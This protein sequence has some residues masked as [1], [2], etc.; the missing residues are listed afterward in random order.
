[1]QNQ[2]VLK[3]LNKTDFKELIEEY[4]NQVLNT[5]LSFLHH[6]EDAEDT[7]QEVF[8]EVYQSLHRFKGQ[9][10]ISTWIYKIAVNKSLEFIRKKKRKKRWG[11]L[12]DLTEWK[13]NE[14]GVEF[15]HPGILLENKER[16]NIL[17]KHIE[18]LPEKQKVAFTLHEFEQLPYKEIAQVME[19]SLSSV[20]SLIYRA[21]QNLKKQL[22]TW[23]ENDKKQ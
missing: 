22:F 11:I 20:E 16:A 7:M 8:I 9:S 6:Q 5:C 4:K 21:K 13:K 2:N 14:A 19:T 12:L 3:N 15:N 18:E 23:Y 17:F 1:M 10:Q